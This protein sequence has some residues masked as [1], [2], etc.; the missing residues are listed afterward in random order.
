MNEKKIFSFLKL[1]ALFSIRNFMLL[2]AGVPANSV[3][4]DIRLYIYSG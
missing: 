2:P 1:Y 4:E 3:L